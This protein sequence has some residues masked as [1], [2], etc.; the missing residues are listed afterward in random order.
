MDR[1][2]SEDLE[3][4]QNEEMIGVRKK[5]SFFFSRELSIADSVSLVTAVGSL[6][7]MVGVLKADVDHN[8]Q[9]VRAVQHWIELREA[10]DRQAAA[11][12]D[13]RLRHIEE[14]LDMLIGEVDGRT[15][16]R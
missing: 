16:N 11:Q 2:Q 1:R 7:W 5:T 10:Q 12:L 4:M 14:K 8:A 6:I 9:E 13:D 3:R 15:K